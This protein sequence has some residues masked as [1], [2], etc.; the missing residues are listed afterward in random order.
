MKL[1]LF[2]S[3]TILAWKH[4][5]ERGAPEGVRISVPVPFYLVEHE[6][7]FVLFDTGQQV[8]EQ[9]FSADAPF[10]PRVKLE[11][12]AVVQLKKY[13]VQPEMIKYIVLSHHHSDHSQGLPDFPGVPC[14]VRKEELQYPYMRQLK[15]QDPDREWIHPE[16][17]LDL[18]GD[19]S[20]SCIP[21]PGHTLGHQSLLLVTAA[22][23]NVLLAGDAAY[24]EAALKQSP[25]DAEKDHPYWRTIGMFQKFINDTG[26]QIITGHDP[27]VWES[28]QKQYP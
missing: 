2:S 24:T 1:H 14:I 9:E 26:L 8:P 11:D 16:D 10:I 3:G 15:E 20:V 4:L 18:F 5:L 12:R 25:P 6:K 28:L 23:R 19:G 22:D 21:T 27:D 17:S 13:G 7:G